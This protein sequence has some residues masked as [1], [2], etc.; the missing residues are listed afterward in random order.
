MKPQSLTRSLILTSLV[1]LLAASLSLLVVPAQ[2][3]R[4][5]GGGWPTLTP[6]VTL[7]PIMWDVVTPVPTFE[8]VIFP[9][10]PPEKI[11]ITGDDFLP[12]NPL[13]Q[14]S[15]TPAEPKSGGMSPTMYMLALGGVILGGILLLLF[16]RRSRS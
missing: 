15:P 11:D 10:M 4:A 8:V 2:S 6:T 5:D 7:T 13:L 1:L 12:D 9:T 3:V 14:P 16:I